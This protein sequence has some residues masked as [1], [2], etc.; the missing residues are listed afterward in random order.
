L[1]VAL[2]GSTISLPIF[3]A[4]QILGKEKTLK[5]IDNTLK[6]VEAKHQA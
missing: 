1:R 2:C 5:G 3:D 6:I 4:V